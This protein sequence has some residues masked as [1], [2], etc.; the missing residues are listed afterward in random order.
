MIVLNVQA[1]VGSAHGV[2]VYSVVTQWMMVATVCEVQAHPFT[3]S[4]LSCGTLMSE[5]K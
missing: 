5:N 3:N 4:T 1:T 2:E